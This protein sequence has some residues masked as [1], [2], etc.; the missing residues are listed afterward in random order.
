MKG[1][2]NHGKWGARKARN[3]YNNKIRAMHRRTSRVGEG[4]GGGGGGAVGVYFECCIV[5][6][7]WECQRITRRSLT[8]ERKQKNK[9]KLITVKLKRSGET[10]SSS[11]RGIRATTGHCRAGMGNPVPCAWDLWN[12]TR[13]KPALNSLRLTVLSVLRYSF[14]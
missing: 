4:L 10:S 12:A 6:P 3:N 5:L 1:V 8:E 9:S 14:Q 7:V 2:K 13:Q 11:S